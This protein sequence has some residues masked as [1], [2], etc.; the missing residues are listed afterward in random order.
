VCTVEGCDKLHHRLL[1]FTESR[2][3][4]PSKEN[5]PNAVCS[6]VDTNVAQP[7]VSGLSIYL[8]V[9]PVVVNHGEKRVVTHTFL[10]PGSSV[11]FCEKKLVDKLGAVG[12]P[13]SINIQTLS[14]PRMLDTVA[15]SMSVE[16]VRGE[17]RLELTEAVAIDEIP[18]KPNA[19]PCDDALKG[20]SYLRGVD[21]PEVE[22][23]TVNLMIGV[24]Y[25][26]ALHVEAVCEGNEHCPDAVCTPLGWSLLG[27][28][29]DSTNSGE[30]ENGSSFCVAH[31]GAHAVL[32]SAQAMFLSDESDAL[33]DSV[34]VDENTFDNTVSSLSREDRLTYSLML[35]SIEFVDGHYQLPFPWRNDLQFLPNN[36]KTVE[37]RLMGLKR[38][39]ILRFVRR[40]LNRCGS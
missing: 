15:V 7:K 37:K 21:L 32:E 2:D 5:E 24:N 40:T 17:D 16:P 38:R 18:V 31:I 19:A 10:D 22:G 28:A 13:K 35:Q 3:K 9:L 14:G 12:S 30:N 39:L 6:V 8:N 33:V 1:H 20:H 25:P 27:P 36:L 34:E 23:A 26:E 11:S 29:F 4:N